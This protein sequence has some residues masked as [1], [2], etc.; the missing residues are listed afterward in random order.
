MT[1]NDTAPD[2][3]TL[4]EVLSRLAEK[5]QMEEL[6]RPEV[7][8]YASRTDTPTLKSL[9]REYSAEHERTVQAIAGLWADEQIEKASPEGH[10]VSVKLLYVNEGKTP[11]KWV[12]TCVCGW[13][14]LSWQWIREDSQ[15]GNPNPTLGGALPMALE[16]VKKEPYGLSK[17]KL[18]SLVS[19]YP[20]FKRFVRRKVEKFEGHSCC[21]D[22]TS[23]LLSSYVKY[24]ASGQ[25]KSDM[26]SVSIFPQ[27]AWNRVAVDSLPLWFSLLQEFTYLIK[28]YDND[29]T[30]AYEEL[31]SWYREQYGS[32]DRHV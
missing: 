2:D 5:F 12:S 4:E 25:V 21:V 9:H 11:W 29:Y 13:K 17:M 18:S 19:H 26:L 23:S 24:T 28:G 6:A 10:K 20:T 16:H 27:S 31:E 1:H 14:F 7:A 32:D 3:N 22:K 8:A 30:S 15:T